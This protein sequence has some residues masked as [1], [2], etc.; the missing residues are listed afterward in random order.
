MIVRWWHRHEHI[1]IRTGYG[2]TVAVRSALRFP[3][4]SGVIALLLLAVPA[5]AQDVGKVQELERVIDDQ[6]R[7][8]EAQQAQLD[9]QGQL[10]QALQ[11]QM[12][13]L[14]AG[15][16]VQEPTVAAEEP[17]EPPVETVADAQEATDAAEEPKGE[18]AKATPERRRDILS[19]KARHDTDTPSG[20]AV[21]YS[22]SAVT[23]TEPKTKTE[24]GL[25]GFAEFQIIY[26]TNGSNN[27]E[28]DTFLIPVPE[29]DPQTKFSV[30]PSRL[31]FTSKTPLG[32]GR[33]NTLVSMDFNG[34]LDSAEP[35]LREAYGEFIQDD[36]DFAVLG[37][38]TFSTMLNL[39]SVPETLDFAGPTGYFAR[40]QPLLRFS[41]L[42]NHEFLLDISAETPENVVYIDATS[43]T[44]APDFAVALAFDDAESVYLDN[45]RLLALFRDLGAKDDLAGAEDWVFGWAV[46]GSGKVNL[47]FLAARDNLKFGVQYGEG[48]GGQLKSGPA[49][50]V[51]N[52][53]T[54]ELE[55]IGVFSTYGGIQHWWTETIRSNAVFGYVKAYNPG[56]I[57]DDR[58]DNT[59]YFAGNLVWNPWKSVTVGV[60]YLRG[61][62]ENADGES[63]NANRVLFHS[64]YDF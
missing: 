64:K 46:G 53:V 43:R 35:R 40:R 9:A 29:G 32:F 16:D 30:N 63:A 42:F 20:S 4:A 58:L 23:I 6:Q 19:D 39:K 60:E 26:D 47:P 49:D 59:S 2:G 57:G 38:Q 27:N 8:L 10:L 3:L 18:I 25:H 15:V 34:E 17:E 51:F 28:F 22:K 44:R 54:L 50:A 7:Q 33:L 14:A 21:Q 1:T 36:L 62:R 5:L 31:G 52:P 11:E 24:I 37:G 41:K 55:T 61:R 56:F 12:K 13:S 48:Y 45:I